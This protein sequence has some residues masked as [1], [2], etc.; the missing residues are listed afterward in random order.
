MKWY[1]EMSEAELL[2]IKIHHHYLVTG[3]TDNREVV[4]SAAFVEIEDSRPVLMEVQ[5]L[6]T[7]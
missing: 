4:D 2:P 6:T 5:V 7:E 1:F 3:N